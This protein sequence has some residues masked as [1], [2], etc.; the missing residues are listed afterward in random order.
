MQSNKDEDELN[1][2]TIKETNRGDKLRKSGQIGDT[3]LSIV[4]SSKYSL[5]LS[6]CNEIEST[7]PLFYISPEQTQLIIHAQQA[8]EHRSESRKKVTFDLI[9]GLQNQ[10]EMVREMIDVPLKHPEV[11]TNFGKWLSCIGCFVGVIAVLVKF[12]I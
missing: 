9:G 5:D 8:K 10:V 1:N 11:F 12:F 7:A 2:S 4:Y 3:Q 6:H